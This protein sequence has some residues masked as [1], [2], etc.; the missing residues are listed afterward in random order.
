[1]TQQFLA[2][3]LFF[4]DL[5][6]ETTTVNNINHLNVM[7]IFQPQI[8]VP[9]HQQYPEQIHFLMWKCMAV[10][11]PQQSKIL[12]KVSLCQHN[13]DF[14]GSEAFA[15]SWGENVHHNA[16]KLVLNIE[17]VKEATDQCL[18]SVIQQLCTLH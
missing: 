1:M 4:W 12:H 3:C 15:G 13:Q 11:K 16:E 9:A 17:N 18:N 8:M 10:R 6:S 14:A 5:N 2:G 7:K